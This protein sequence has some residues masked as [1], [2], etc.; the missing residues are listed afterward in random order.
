MKIAIIG[1]GIGGL[2]T[3]NWLKYHGIDFELLEQAPELT[4]I[5]AVESASDKTETLDF[6]KVFANYQSR[7]EDKV[8]QI[9]NVSW[10]FGKLAHAKSPV[11]NAISRAM[12]RIIPNFTLRKQE[13]ILNDLSYN[14]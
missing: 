7:R 5:G 2:T 10:K 3:A 6:S 9:V 8:M 12:W 4:E 1:G 11:I 14:D 13:A